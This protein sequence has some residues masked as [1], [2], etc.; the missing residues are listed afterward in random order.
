MKIGVDIDEVLAP[1][2]PSMLKWKRTKSLPKTYP[3][4]FSTIYN[5]SENDS[6]KLVHEFYDSKEFL[7]LKPIK[8]SQKAM[9]HLKQQDHKLYI[10]T[11]RQKVVKQKTEDWIEKWYPG[12]FED[13][14]LTNSFTPQEVLKSDVCSNINIGLIIDDNFTTCVECISKGTEAINF[15]G[16]PVYPWCFEN[17]ISKNS[18]KQIIDTSRWMS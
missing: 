13:V 11:G 7:K 17:K 2:L 15:I 18:W 16:D 6:Q 9:K 1:F 10:I 5:I 14:I 12:I 4:I 3:Y 8:N